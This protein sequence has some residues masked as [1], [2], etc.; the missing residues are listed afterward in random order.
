MTTKKQKSKT[1][2]ENARQEDNSTKLSKDKVIGLVITFIS[3]MLIVYV[4]FLGM[5]R[6]PVSKIS[7]EEALSTLKTIYGSTWILDD[8]GLSHRLATRGEK[9]EK[10]FLTT[11][12]D[13]DKIVLP[14]F[15]YRDEK[16]EVL[17]K[18]LGVIYFHDEN[19]LLKVQLPNSKIYDIV[20]SKS[21]NNQMENLAFI[22]GGNKRTYYIKEELIDNE[23]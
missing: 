11:D 5:G 20:Y 9:Y 14:I 13:R 10:I 15:F 1:K 2:D 18:D 4:A 23:N 8:K 3:L 17:G 6:R 19:S 22:L 7:R 12:L 16:N 21:K